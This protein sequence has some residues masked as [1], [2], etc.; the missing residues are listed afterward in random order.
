MQDC[1][2]FEVPENHQLSE[3]HIMFRDS[4]LRYFSDLGKQKFGMVDQTF[5]EMEKHFITEAHINT[6]TT[7]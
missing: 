4:S 3:L 2:A 7:E 5:D 6:Y 1:S